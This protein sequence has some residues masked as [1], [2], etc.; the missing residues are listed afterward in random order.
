EEADI[1]RWMSQLEA[2]LKAQGHTLGEFY[3]ERGLSEEQLRQSVIGMLQWAGYVKCRLSDNELKQY[4]ELNR[5]F[6]DQ[7]SVRASHIMVRVSQTASE[8]GRQAAKAR[9][10]GLRQ[11]LLSGKT[12]FAEAVKKHSQCPS[13]ANGGD[14]GYFPR[15]FAFEEAF[16]RAAFA[17]KPGEIS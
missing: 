16:A 10:V 8:S 5:D 13:A 15:K 6:F 2:T 7:V 12:D 4:Y 3:K 11:E 9:L 14:V 17:L 1:A